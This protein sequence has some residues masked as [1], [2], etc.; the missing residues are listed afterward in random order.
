MNDTGE[1][2]VHRATQSTSHMPTKQNISLDSG[3]SEPAPYKA[4]STE[5]SSKALFEM[6]DAGTHK[7]SYHGSKVLLAS[8]LLKRCPFDNQWTAMIVEIQKQK[9]RSYAVEFFISLPGSQSETQLYREDT[10]M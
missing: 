8:M 4:T 1:E 9:K 10:I 3:K 2:K 6:T 5:K 7:T